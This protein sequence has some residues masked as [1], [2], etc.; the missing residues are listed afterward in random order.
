MAGVSFVRAILKKVQPILTRVQNLA[1]LPDVEALNRAGKYRVRLD[2]GSGLERNNFTLGP[3]A[4][5]ALNF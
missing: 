4:L 5:V 1:G 2:G 3:V